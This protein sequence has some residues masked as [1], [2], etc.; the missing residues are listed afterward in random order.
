MTVILSANN[1]GYEYKIREGIFK[2]FHHKALSEV[3]FDLVK[4]ETLGVIGKNGS[5]KSSLLQ[6]LAGL[7]RPTT[8][9]IDLPAGPLR[10][11]LLTLGLGFRPDL[12]GF[13]N[14]IISLILQNFSKHQAIDMIDGIRAVA[15]IGEYF[16]KPV[17]TYS[18]GM[19]ARLGFATGICSEVDVLL[20]DEVLSV[21]DAQ[22][23]QRAEQTMLD[24]LSGQQTVVMVSQSP[25]QIRDLCDRAIWIHD[26]GIQ[27][28][29]DPKVISREYIK[30]FELNASLT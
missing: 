1:V 27:A 18:A 9:C 11:S 4:G 16:D 26:S 22:F 13:D 12:S 28:I 20:I 24:R 17:R 21:G 19:R 30:H 25:A 8:G 10:R 7:L 15:D 29:G 5:G 2:S 6:I 23:R 3:T 14:V